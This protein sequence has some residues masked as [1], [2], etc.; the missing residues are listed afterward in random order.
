MKY[1]TVD[2]RWGLFGFENFESYCQN[3]IVKGS[4]NS[5]VPDDVVSE[6][7]SAEYMMAHA[8]YFYPL[9]HEAFSK[10]LRIIEMAV[11]LR[12]SQRNIQLKMV[13]KRNGKEHFENRVLKHLMDDLAKDEPQKEL[14]IRFD[15]ARNLRNSLMHP[16]AHVISG[17]L[18]RGYIMQAINLLNTLFLEEAVIAFFQQE[19]NNINQRIKPFNEGLFVLKLNEKRYLIKGLRVAANIFIDGKWDYLVVALPIMLNPLENLQSHSYI[20]PLA[21]IASALTC[22]TEHELHIVDKITGQLIFLE[23]TDQS[24]NLKIYNNYSKAVQTITERDRSMYLINSENEIDKLAEQFWYE[25][26]CLIK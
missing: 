21:V 14:G 19:L 3:L 1:H 15:V 16:D 10:V 20:K 4:F 6:Y 24:E 18:S 8:Y 13:R 11:K 7:T 5:K 12:C 23:T 2:E 25:K 17:A 9:Y 26:L 22:I